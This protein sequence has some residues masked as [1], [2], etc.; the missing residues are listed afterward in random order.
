[1]TVEDDGGDF[2]GG[3]YSSTIDIK[4]VSDY[5]G[6]NFE[7]ALALDCFTYRVL[8]RDAIIFNYSKTEDG[9]DYL[10]KCWRMKQT[11]PDYEG[12]QRQFKKGV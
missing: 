10:K 1:M 11:Q 4:T 3:Y 7:E 8:L 12:L 9:R 6:L 5:S 2:N